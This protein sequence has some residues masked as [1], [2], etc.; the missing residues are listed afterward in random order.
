MKIT[1]KLDNKHILIW[2]KGREGKSSEKFLLEHC[3]AATY[4]M[5]EGSEDDIQKLSADFDYILKS[6]GIITHIEDP[7]YISQTRLF[8]EEFRSQVVGIT[9]TKGKSTTS[10]LL[11][12][13]L[14]DVR[15]GNAIL[16]GNIGLPCFDYYDD[17]S[18]DTIV[19]YELSCHQ[20]SDLETSPHVAVFLNLYEDH[21]DRYITMENYFRA[22]KNITIHQGPEDYLFYGNDVPEIETA[23]KKNLLEFDRSMAF[24]MKLQGAHNQFNATFVYRICTEVFGLDPDAVR[25][26]IETFTGLH[27]RLEFVGNFDG[28]DFYNDS[29]STIPQATI[30]AATSIKNTGTLLIGGMDRGI[31]YTTL[32]AFIKDHPEYQYICA[33]ESG[34]RIYDEVGDL[35][36]CHLVS[37]IRESVEMARKITPQGKACIMSPAAASYTHFKDFEARGE[38]FCQLVKGET[39]LVFTGDIGFDRYMDHKW[40]DPKLLSKRVKDVLSFADH[41][42]ANVEGPIMECPKNDVNEGAK[43]LLHFM[44]PAVADFLCENHCD[45][46]NICNNHIKDAGVEGIASTLKEAEKRGIKTI[47]AGMNIEEAR[48][49]LTLPEAGGIGMFG[50]GYQRACRKATETEAGCFSWSDLDAIREAITEIKKTCRWCIVVAHAGEEFTPLPS[51]YTRDRYHLYL[52][53]GADIVVAHHPHVP[54]NYEMVGDKAIFYSL[55][56]F[57]FD[58]D[59]QRSQYNTEKGLLLSLKFSK[60][61]FSF[62]PYGLDII[63]GDEHVDLGELPVIFQDVPEEEYKLLSPLSVKMHIAATRRQMTYLDPKRFKNATEEEWKAHFEEPMRT[64]RVPGET[65]D[66]FI[67]C[68]LAEQAEKED[69]K[70]SKMQDI[71]KYIQDQM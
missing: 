5:V 36:Y 9:G 37:D 57:I 8:M 54:M 58:T 20:L 53:M 66:F 68:P 40:Q 61:A 42:I 19:V 12:H 15:N 51:P 32:I 71:V 59:Y 28:I 27:H 6:P 17:I 52:E 48:K 4:E 26:S 67:L 13:V 56:N 31:D 49:I 30:Q 39:T 62:T 25:K 3:P 11:Y 21:L 2:G 65:L 55:G 43:Q 50:V 60:D 34:K 70:R 18:K 35:P 46:W 7:K 44:D 47:G 38:K 64:G 14:H 45:I 29:I 33:Y 22:K 63:R 41:V 69:W 1:E 10:S 23:A 16:C 24:D